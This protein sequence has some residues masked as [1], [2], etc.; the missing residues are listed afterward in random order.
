MNLATQLKQ[1]LPFEV[2]IRP[3]IIKQLKYEFSTSVEF[4]WWRSQ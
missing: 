2:Q 4:H 3:E 1:H